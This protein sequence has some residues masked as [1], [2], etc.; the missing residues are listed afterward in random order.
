VRALGTLPADSTPTKRMN[1]RPS[2]TLVL[3]AFVR[4]TIESLQDKH[5]EH[6]DA[7]GGFAPSLA[8]T[9]LL[10]HALQDRAK[11]LPVND[12]IESLQGAPVLLKL[13]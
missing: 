9:L 6:E 12:G 10:V 2:V 11:Y 13:A 1:D 5:L 4:Q 7:R 3:Q 8:F